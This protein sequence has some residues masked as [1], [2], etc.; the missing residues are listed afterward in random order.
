MEKL[1][2]KSEKKAAKKTPFP[3]N[4]FLKNWSQNHIY[5]LEFFKKVFSSMGSPNPQL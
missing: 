2:F 4:N 3:A 5:P 1:C